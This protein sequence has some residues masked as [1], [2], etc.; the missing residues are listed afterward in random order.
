M[1]I[2]A[3]IKKLEE[4]IKDLKEE[5][6][7]EIAN[8]NTPLKKRW[9]LFVDAPDPLRD[10]QSWIQHFDLENRVGDISWYDDFYKERYA[11]VRM[12]DI[13]DMCEEYLADGT[14]KGGFNTQE[15]IDA[16]KEEILKKNLGSFTYDW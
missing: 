7:F 12:V 1:N 11:L 15:K 13:I 10:H 16:F 4:R 14:P 8:V 9:K 3:K 5:F 6:K 2:L